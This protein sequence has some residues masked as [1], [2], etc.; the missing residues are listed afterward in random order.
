MQQGRPN[1]FT[2]SILPR[3]CQ[4]LRDSSHAP[5]STRDIKAMLVQCWASVEDSGPTL[6]LHWFIVCW[7]IIL[8][9]HLR[10]SWRVKAMMW[11]CFAVADTPFH[12]QQAVMIND[13]TPLGSGHPNLRD[14]DAQRS[15]TSLFWT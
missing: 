15:K 1:K 8:L 5:S 2:L 6:K 9:N 11:L 12:I 10:C 4:G 13:E 7:I 3:S 14:D